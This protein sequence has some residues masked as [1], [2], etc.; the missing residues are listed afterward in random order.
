[1]SE[2][3]EEDRNVTKEVEPVTMDDVFNYLPN[4]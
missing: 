3:R 2:G 4:N 1:M